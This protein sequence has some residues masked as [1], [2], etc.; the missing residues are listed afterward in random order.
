[1]TRKLPWL[2]GIII[3]TALLMTTVPTQA[4]AAPGHLGSPQVICVQANAQITPHRAHVG[5]QIV[6]QASIHNCGRTIYLHWVLRLTAPCPGQSVRAGERGRFLGG[7]TVEF[8]P[9]TD[10]QAC[11]GTYRVIAKAFHDGRLVDRARRYA[12]VRP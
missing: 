6:F 10:R 5:D 9:P 8:A 11:R 3:V 1:M 12:H 2:A 7:L 4:G